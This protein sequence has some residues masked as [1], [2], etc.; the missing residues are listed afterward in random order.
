M[1]GDTTDQLLSLLWW[2]TILDQ[3]P[4]PKEAPKVPQDTTTAEE[5]RV[6]R[7]RRDYLER[8]ATQRC[9]DCDSDG[10]LNW[11]DVGGVRFKCPHDPALYRAAHDE[12]HGQ[13]Q[14]A[15]EAWEIHNTK[16][17][18]HHGANR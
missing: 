17:N 13:L 3:L 10:W 11:S 14:A 12:R 2:V 16:G 4:A 9:P 15:T 6:E 7:D 18:Q 8:R 5:R 1:T